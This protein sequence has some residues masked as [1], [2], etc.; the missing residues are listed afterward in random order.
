MTSLDKFVRVNGERVA[1]KVIDGEAILIDM[2]TG[3]Y[4]SMPGTAGFI[5]SLM[6]G[7]SSLKRIVEA[8]SGRYA[9]D[10]ATAAAD[11]VA[12]AAQLSEEGLIELT[13]EGDDIQPDIGTAD[14]QA[15]YSAPSYE[16]FSDMAEMFALDPPLPGLANPD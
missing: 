4:Y 8:V 12:L 6:E 5:W 16:K 15:E 9:A 3:N 11:V 14:Q 10:E 2:T 13:A 1:A 7:G